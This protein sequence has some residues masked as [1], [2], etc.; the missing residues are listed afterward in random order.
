MASMH[1]I[2]SFKHAV[3]SIKLS[4]IGLGPFDDRGY[5]LGNSC[6]KLAYGHYT[7]REDSRD[8]HDQELIELFADL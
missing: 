7:L 4:K 8:Q 1:Q 6:V 3:C 5:I 2:R